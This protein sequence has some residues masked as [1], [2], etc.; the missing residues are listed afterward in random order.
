VP[1]IR[2]RGVR[3]QLALIRG[4]GRAAIT[5]GYV[6]EANLWRIDPGVSGRFVPETPLVGTIAAALQTI[7]VSSAATIDVAE[8]ASPQGGFIDVTPDA[9]Q[10]LVPTGANY[11]VTLSVEALD[12][13]LPS[14]LRGAVYLQGRVESFLRAG[15]RRVLKVLVRESAA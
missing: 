13:D 11:L 14:P 3:K 15:W 4:I 1:E 6:A 12:R 7:A 2:P 10:R 9:W 5:T 8:L